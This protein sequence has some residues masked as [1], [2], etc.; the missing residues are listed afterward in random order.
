MQSSTDGVLFPGRMNLIK[1]TI[2]LNRNSTGTA[3]IQVI[4][5]EIIAGLFSLTSSFVCQILVLVLRVRL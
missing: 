2:R 3:A 4:A 1:V 5:K